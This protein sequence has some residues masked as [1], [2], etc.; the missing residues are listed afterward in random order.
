MSDNL[1]HTKLSHSLQELSQVEK[2]MDEEMRHFDKTRQ[3]FQN[4]L[5]SHFLIKP[6]V[7]SNFTESITHYQVRLSERLARQRLLVD[8]IQQ[9]LASS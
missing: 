1:S 2:L 3:E 4:E 5:D 6:S 7:V 8:Y 9:L